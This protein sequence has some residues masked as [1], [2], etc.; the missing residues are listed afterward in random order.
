MAANQEKIDEMRQTFYALGEQDHKRAPSVVSSETRMGVIDHHK[1]LELL[2][3]GVGMLTSKGIA[4]HG[5]VED[6][7]FDHIPAPSPGRT[8]P[9][10]SQESPP[11]MAPPETAPPETAQSQTE[12]SQTEPSQTEPMTVTRELNFEGASDDEA[13]TA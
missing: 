2:W 6:F 11:E 5:Q 10:A 9:S 3:A 12:P 8:Q 13:M 7:D 1:D 4:T